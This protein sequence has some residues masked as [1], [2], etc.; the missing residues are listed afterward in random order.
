[1]QNYQVMIGDK[2]LLTVASSFHF[3]LLEE[4]QHPNC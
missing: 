3:S 2:R 4:G 1:M